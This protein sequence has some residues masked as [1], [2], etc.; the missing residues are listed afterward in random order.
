MENLEFQLL[1]QRMFREKGNWTEHTIHEI[2]R[3]MNWEIQ[4]NTPE[5]R[6]IK[7]NNQSNSSK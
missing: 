1:I 2:E 5:L 3:L 4:L 6:I 7:V